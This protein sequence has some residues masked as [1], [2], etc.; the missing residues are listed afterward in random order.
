[1]GQFLLDS[2]DQGFKS[3][4][5]PEDVFFPS[6]PFREIS[7]I[8]EGTLTKFYPNNFGSFY[9]RSIGLLCVASYIAQQILFAGLQTRQSE[10][11]IYYLKSIQN[12]E[13][14]WSY[15]FLL[16]FALLSSVFYSVFPLHP[17]HLLSTLASLS[18]APLA[19]DFHWLIWYCVIITEESKVPLMHNFL[20]SVLVR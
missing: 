6:I 8:Q 13:C 19:P 9:P 16:N 17:F 18:T 15:F 5:K 12:Q 20:S 4:F 7:C 1:M 10:A 14:A 11:N 3:T 2:L